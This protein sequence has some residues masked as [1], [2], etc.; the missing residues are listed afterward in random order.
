M[1][2]TTTTTTFAERDEKNASTYVPIKKS[3]LTAS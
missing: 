3:S 1:T 2:T